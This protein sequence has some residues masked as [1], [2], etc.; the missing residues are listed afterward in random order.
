MTPIHYAG[1]AYAIQFRADEER[2]ETA[3]GRFID[4]DRVIPKLL[5]ASAEA[6]TGPPC[7]DGNV[8]DRL[9][10]GGPSTAE[11]PVFA[12]DASGRASAEGVRE[13]ARNRSG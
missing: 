1:I 2:A 3:L 9:V 4:A 7:S 13:T 12:L 6:S 11:C 8:P 5:A 10:D